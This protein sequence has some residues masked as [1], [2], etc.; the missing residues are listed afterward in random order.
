MTL[1]HP[2]TLSEAR[3]TLAAWRRTEHARRGYEGRNS[4]ST[5]RMQDARYDRAVRQLFAEPEQRELAGTVW[6]EH[7]LSL[8]LAGVSHDERPELW[9]RL[10]LM[11]RKLRAAG[12]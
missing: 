7:A 9:E 1:L 3:K 5:S 11:R 8:R 12:I 2:T 4:T 10:R 6:A